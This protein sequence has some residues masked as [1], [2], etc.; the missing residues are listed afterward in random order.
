MRDP[1]YP[2]RPAER[3]GGFAYFFLEDGV[4]VGL[5]AETRALGDHLQ[6][7][8]R[9]GQQLD[10]GVDAET[11]RVPAGF[12]CCCRCAPLGIDA[13]DSNIQKGDP[14]ER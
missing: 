12:P 7:Q 8:L 14:H 1:S 2:R 10:R 5:G 3:A 4:H 13:A 11:A 6:L 9:F